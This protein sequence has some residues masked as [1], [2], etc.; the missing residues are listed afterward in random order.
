MLP[1]TPHAAVRHL[2][3]A[4]SDQPFAHK[5]SIKQSETPIRWTGDSNNAAK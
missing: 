5:S 2:R 1:N 4:Q 3:K